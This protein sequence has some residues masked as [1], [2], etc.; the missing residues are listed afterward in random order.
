MTEG[1]R[2]PWL[3]VTATCD[4]LTRALQAAEQRAERA[5]AALREID[6]IVSFWVDAKAARSRISEI[7][8]AA[9]GEP[10]D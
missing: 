8:Y 6:G 1:E 4:D 10:N 2:K 9:L 5:E 7:I 3:A